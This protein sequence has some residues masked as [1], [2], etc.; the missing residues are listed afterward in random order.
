M[1]GKHLLDE[2]SKL[3]ELSVNVKMYLIIDL[4]SSYNK[5][6][7]I[8]DIGNMVYTSR[9]YNPIINLYFVHNVHISEHLVL[10]P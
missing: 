10:K 6:I 4:F 8:R 7:G 1:G 3:Y 2:S 5:S 9:E